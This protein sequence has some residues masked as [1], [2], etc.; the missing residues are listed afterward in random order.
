M[1]RNCAFISCGASVWSGTLDGGVGSA[2]PAD[3]EEL[4]AA[5]CL[6]LNLTTSSGDF[7][8][9]HARG[10][11]SWTNATVSE[12]F[13]EAGC[14]FGTGAGSSWSSFAN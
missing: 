1:K 4:G 14:L 13:R 11:P 6:N 9:A 3:E 12:V 2:G 7:Q 8:A 10:S 5:G